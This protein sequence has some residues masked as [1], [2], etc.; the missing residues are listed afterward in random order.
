[1]YLGQNCVDVLNMLENVD[2]DD[3]IEG[4]IL[5]RDRLTGAM[6]V[7]DREAPRFGMA[8]RNREC[9]LRRIDSGYNRSTPGQ[10][11][12]HKA[13]AATQIEHTATLP[14]I[15]QQIEVGEACRH[16]I[17]QGT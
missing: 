6:Q 7:D 10:S 9:R 3:L 13:T 12:R 1:M 15:Y 17:V 5:D 8:A 14:G 11:F 2:T 16:Q 4:G